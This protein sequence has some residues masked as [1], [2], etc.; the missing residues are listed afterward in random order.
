MIPEEA[1][2]QVPISIYHERV[3]EEL[4]NTLLARA[5]HFHC[6]CGNRVKIGPLA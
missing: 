2:T 3:P 1:G 4:R 6:L 5:T